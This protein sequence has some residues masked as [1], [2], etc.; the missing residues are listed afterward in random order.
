MSGVVI[1]F[2]RPP[3]GGCR[4]Q[5]KNKAKS[6]ANCPPP[7][8][9][10]QAPLEIYDPCLQ[11]S[12]PPAHPQPA[13]GKLQIY[14]GKFEKVSAPD[15]IGFP[16]SARGKEP[17]CQCRRCKRHGFDPWVRKIPWWRAW[18]HTPV[19]LLRIPRR[20]EP[21]GVRSKGSQSQTWLKQLSMHAD[22]CILFSL[23][24]HSRFI[25]LLYLF[26]VHGTAM[27]SSCP[28]EQRSHLWPFL[29]FITTILN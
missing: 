5:T 6:G 22:T 10:P 7:P 17:A 26:S 25:H 1:P 20:E 21:G 19:F 11:S 12:Q 29:S 15:L 2:S 28:S 24:V 23:S 27:L 4:L 8:A 18:Q 3:T 9:W 13:T 16:G 14:I